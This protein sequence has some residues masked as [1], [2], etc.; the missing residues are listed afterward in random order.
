[1]KLPVTIHLFRKKMVP[2]KRSCLVAEF[3]RRELVFEHGEDEP[4]V[5]NRNHPPH[6]VNAPLGHID[7][8]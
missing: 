8:G 4:A 7:A 5:S 3:Y 2:S 1:M 6:A